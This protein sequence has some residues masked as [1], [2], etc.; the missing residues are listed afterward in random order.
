MT[1]EN[2]TYLL[3][4]LGAIFVPL[5]VGFTRKFDF[6]RFFKAYTPAILIPA[7]IFIIWDIYFTSEGI[8][9]FTDRYLL[10][11][12]I[13]GLPL[14]EILFF[15]CIPFACLF[16]YFCIRKYI[17]V[18]NE[19]G[20]YL[21]FLIIFMAIIGMYFFYEQRYTSST[22]LSLI[23]VHL[24]ARKVLKNQ[25]TTVFFMMYVL[26]LVP[27]FIV[28]GLL[29]GTGLEEQVVWYNDTQ[30]LSIRVGTI[31]IEDFFYGMSLLLS[32]V[33]LFEKLVTKHQPNFR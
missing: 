11:I 23:I 10:G 13:L 25:H 21:S 31:P 7:L 26:T 3:I 19:L 8:W 12:D 33:I 2:Y 16:T 18:S 9:G 1:L 20:I 24:I 15:I 29:T 6:N 4:N 30:N 22:C 17:N 28:N 5:V 14:E 27:F 32:N